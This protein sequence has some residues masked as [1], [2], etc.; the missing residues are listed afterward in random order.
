MVKIMMDVKGSLVVYGCRFVLIQDFTVLIYLELDIIEIWSSKRNLSTNVY[1]G[2]S[3][4]NP[5]DHGIYNE[6]CPAITSSFNVARLFA[7]KITKKQTKQIQL[8]MCN[9][10]TYMY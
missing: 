9:V 5:L 6:L 4:G 2:R 1:S 3:A 10:Q 8:S 7:K